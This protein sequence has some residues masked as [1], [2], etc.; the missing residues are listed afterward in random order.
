MKNRFVHILI[1]LFFLLLLSGC[2]LPGIKKEA[3]SQ[4][5]AM[6]T[7]MSVDVYGENAKE[8]LEKAR[9]EITRLDDLLSTGKQAS[10]VSKINENSGGVLS[11][12]TELLLE[13]SMSLYQETNGNFD[14]TIYPVMKLWGFADQTFQIPSKEALESTLQ[15]VNG[16]LLDYDA[17][18]HTL[19]MPEGMQIDFGG[20]AKGYTSQRISEII[21]QNGIEHAMID[22]GGNIQVVG[23]KPDGSDWRIAVKD[24]ENT[25]RYLGII[26]TS[27]MA[28]I[29]SG[30]Y[31]R[32]FEEE[33]IRY[34][35]IIDP[36]TGYPAKEELL[37]VTIVCENGMLA[38]GLS[39]SLFI[40]GLEKSV[41]Y[42]RTHK[43]MFEMVLYTSD[44]RLLISKGLENCFRTQ[45][46]YEV[47]EE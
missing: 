19:C 18:T 40:M 33:G 17:S 13:A 30:G 42:W 27:D 39:T 21:K 2:S 14:I 35:H 38:D 31:E 36:K 8:V 7:Y 25:Q 10:E 3:G 47:I 26:S 24:P 41:E 37:S 32:Y 20:I 23:K 46:K 44:R 6:D 29:T 15:K 43:D 28:V 16:S 22:L 34:H 4:F 9:Q 1:S 11:E 45:N 12:D 5:F